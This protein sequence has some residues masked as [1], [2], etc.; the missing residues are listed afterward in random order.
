MAMTS[1]AKDNDA[2]PDKS[3]RRRLTWGC[4]LVSYLVGLISLVV[5]FALSPE[6]H[7]KFVETFSDSAAIFLTGV[8]F[9]IVT[10]IYYILMGIVFAV[11]GKI[12]AKKI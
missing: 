6:T 8:A 4:V 9:I 3:Q 2:V 1:F 12:V 5:V 10:L 7:V 11:F